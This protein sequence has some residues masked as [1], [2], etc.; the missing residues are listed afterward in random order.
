MLRGLA[1]VNEGLL[2]VIFKS[3]LYCGEVPDN[4][5]KPCYTQLQERQERGSKDKLN[6]NP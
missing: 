1:D 3:S 4:W 2:S 5:K 6:L